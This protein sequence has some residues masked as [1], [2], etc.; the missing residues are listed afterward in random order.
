MKSKFWL[1]FVSFLVIIVAGAVAYKFWFIMSEQK[2]VKQPP[3]VNIP[4]VV[5]PLAT[6]NNSQFGIR[7]S[8]PKELIP[9]ETFKQFYALSSNWRAETT[10]DSKGTPIVAIPVFRIDQGSVATG[11]AYPLYFSAEV[12]VGASSD[13]KDV[14]NCLQNDPG[15]TDQKSTDV[16]INGITFKR[17]EIADAAAMQYVQGLSYR[18]VHNNTCYAVEQLRAGSSYRDGTMTQG[19]SEEQLDAFYQKGDA[20]VQTFKFTK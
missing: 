15:F 9:E 17:F 20:I 7:F 18:T 19:Y 5:N 11:K 1:V 10:P 6:Y 13:K 2:P 14:Q 8:Y 12:R 4:V 16:V 3:V